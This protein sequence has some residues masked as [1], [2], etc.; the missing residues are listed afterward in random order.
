MKQF[1]S[2][3]QTLG[4]I[5]EDLATKF[6]VKHG[7]TVIERNFSSKNGEIDIICEK[8]SSLYF[9]E[10]KSMKYKLVSRETD[11]PSENMTK[12]KIQKIKRTIVDYFINRNVTC[13]TYQIDLCV[14]L[15]DDDARVGNVTLIRNIT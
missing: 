10:V 9:I 13:E 12:A 7:F 8:M 3:R 15:V 4:K 14:V 2:K 1:T 5:G 11:S 6:L